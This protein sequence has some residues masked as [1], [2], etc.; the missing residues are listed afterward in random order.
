MKC[1]VSWHICC[2]CYLKIHLSFYDRS[3]IT[4]FWHVLKEYYK[5]VQFSCGVGWNVW[6]ESCEVFVSV[7]YLS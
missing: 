6:C 5:L 7:W 4:Y 1:I 2:I 3:K